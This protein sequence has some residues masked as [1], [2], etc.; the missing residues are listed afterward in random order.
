MS[1]RTSDA[2]GRHYVDGEWVEGTGGEP[3][4]SANPATGESLGTFARGTPGDVERAVDAAEAAFE[5]WRE[6]SYVERAA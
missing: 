6:R 5:T 3:F 1:Q 2:S 4:E